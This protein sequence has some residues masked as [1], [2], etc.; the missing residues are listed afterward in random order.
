MSHC[1][2]A[3]RRNSIGGKKALTQS[4]RTRLKTCPYVEDIKR[5]VRKRTKMKRK[6]VDDVLGG[7]EAWKNV[8]QA[9]SEHRLRI[10]AMRWSRLI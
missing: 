6:E 2:S 9:E 10:C 7:A 1:T 5:T 3:R 4:R 8:D